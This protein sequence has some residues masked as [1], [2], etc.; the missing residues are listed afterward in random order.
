MG[1]LYTAPGTIHDNDSWVRFVEHDYEYL[2]GRLGTRPDFVAFASWV[3]YPL[4][5]LPES[6]PGSFTH[7]IRDYLQFKG[8]S[9]RPIPPPVPRREGIR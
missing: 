7:L 6:E 5:N 1:I 9:G 8:V 3:K 2:E 4:Y